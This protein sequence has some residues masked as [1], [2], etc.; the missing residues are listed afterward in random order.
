[1]KP[2][3]IMLRSKESFTCFCL[4]SQMQ[5]F[6]TIL[7][8]PLRCILKISSHLHQGLTSGLFPSAF[9]YQNLICNTLLN[10][11][12]IYSVLPRINIEDDGTPSSSNVLF[13]LFFLKP[14]KEF[15]GN[16]ICGRKTQDMERCKTSYWQCL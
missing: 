10:F 8:I 5:S 1:M 2:E 12:G 4:E 11:I 9:Y 7:Y 13:T 14:A 16:F 6:H 3:G 15:I